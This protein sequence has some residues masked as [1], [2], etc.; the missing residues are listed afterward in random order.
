MLTVFDPS[1]STGVQLPENLPFDEWVSLGSRLRESREAVRWWIGDW[2]A[3]G[4]N[5]YGEKYAQA[6]DGSEWDY[7]TL[8]NFVWV[9]RSIP[10]TE[11]RASLTWSHHAEIAAL[12]VASRKELLDKAE[13]EQ[14]TVKELRSVVQERQPASKKKPKGFHIGN[15]LLFLENDELYLSNKDGEVD[16]VNEESLEHHLDAYWK[17]NHF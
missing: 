6:L 11:R 12:P 13:S 4:E 3:Y 17:H 10:L 5:T 9:A 7:Q 14:L 15:Y 1:H 16:S 8:R 2:L